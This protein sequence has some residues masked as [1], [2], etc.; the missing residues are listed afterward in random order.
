MT[1]EGRKKASIFFSFFFYYFLCF[2]FFILLPTGHGPLCCVR[3]KGRGRRE[4]AEKRW[5][6]MSAVMKRTVMNRKGGSRGAGGDEHGR[7]EHEVF[8][9]FTRCIARGKCVEASMNARSV[10]PLDELIGEGELPVQE[11][12]DVHHL[13]SERVLTLQEVAG[14][15]SLVLELDARLQAFSVLR[16]PGEKHTEKD[17][18]QSPV[19]KKGTPRGKKKRT[20]VTFRVFVSRNGYS[21]TTGRSWPA[22]ACLRRSHSL[23]APGWRSV[24]ASQA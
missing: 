23:A 14:D 18:S 6:M 19:K 13:L 17:R 2:Y 20:R 9:R 4:R 12:L 16:R 22:T 15:L 8:P 5:M 24:A 1:K 11:H 10:V 3:G 21:Q 7:D